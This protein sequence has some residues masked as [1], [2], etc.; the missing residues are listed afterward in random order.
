MNVLDLSHPLGENTPAYPGTEPPRIAERLHGREGW[1]RRKASLPLFPYRNPCRCAFPHDRA[2]A[3]TMDSLEAGRFV[4]PGCVVD[5]PGSDGRGSKSPTWRGCGTGSP[6]RNSSLLRSG[7]SERWGDPS[8]FS[9]YPVLSIS[10]AR[11]LAAFPLKGLGVDMI[12]FDEMHS[13]TMDVHK[14]LFSEGHDS[15][16]KSDGAGAVDRPGVRFLVLAVENLRRRRLAGKSGR[17]ATLSG[18][19]PL[20]PKPDDVRSDCRFPFISTRTK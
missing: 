10:A 18:P 5:S 13:T 3:A 11:W 15:R 12:S 20:E 1:V 7:W 16:R 6:N 19:L 8:Y 2:G 4:G 17:P 14:V 9:G